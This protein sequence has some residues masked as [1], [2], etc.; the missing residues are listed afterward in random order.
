MRWFSFLPALAPFFA[1][2]E[3]GPEHLDALYQ[4]RNHF[5]TQI[6]MVEKKYRLKS[7][8]PVKD[9]REQEGKLEQCRL[10]LQDREKQCQVEKASL[11]KEVDSL[12]KER[13]LFLQELT[14]FDDD[15]FKGLPPELQVKWR[16][17]RDL[18]LLD[19][20]R[21]SEAAREESTP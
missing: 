13:D 9:D 6:D 10:A 8:D 2:C 19:P 20:Q 11:A 14:S 18:L 17:H 12:V 15:W 4:A 5:Q 7:R 16:I 1:G 21:R 3:Y